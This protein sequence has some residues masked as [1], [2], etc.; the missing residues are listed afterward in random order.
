MNELAPFG[1][2]LDPGVWAYNLGDRIISRSVVAEVE[3]IG[4]A[5]GLPLM[6][7]A[8]HDDL[9]LRGKKAARLSR[10]IVL[11]G[12][13]SLS[14]TWGS[15]AIHRLRMMDIPFAGNKIVLAGVGSNGGSLDAYSRAIWRRLLDANAPHSVRDEQGADRLV[16]IGIPANRIFM[17]GCPTTWGLEEAALRTTKADRV[18]YLDSAQDDAA[19]T[20]QMLT[21]LGQHYA[22]VF[23]FR[24]V[25]RRRVDALPPFVCEIKG[26]LGAYEAILQ[27][28][29]EVDVVGTRLHGGVRA[30]QAGQRTLILAID[31]RAI[32]QGRIAGLPVRPFAER[33][34][35]VLG[36]ATAAGERP[37]FHVHRNVDRW[38][39][40]LVD[41]W[42]ELGSGG[43]SA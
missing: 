39:S 29:Q 34:A 1:V 2:V 26:G 27:G 9:G 19:D 24:Q 20:N 7:G 33:H 35:A 37:K 14:R 6:L 3:R 13:N 16:S 8:W 43:G 23:V 38:R 18:V 30:L 40:S 32:E 10:T 22:Q 15:S 28:G 31:H 5:A 41:Y 17:T 36:F 11:A 21:L 25:V 12:A 42:Q 4:A